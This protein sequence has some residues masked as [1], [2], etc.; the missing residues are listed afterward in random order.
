MH[1]TGL[2]CLLMIKK[3]VFDKT[4]WGAGL[5]TSV[6]ITGR[7]VQWGLQKMGLQKWGLQ[8][9]RETQCPTKGH[10]PNLPLA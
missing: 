1:N 3:H 5:S 8:L 6:F 7:Y 2:S 4:T 10:I 9:G